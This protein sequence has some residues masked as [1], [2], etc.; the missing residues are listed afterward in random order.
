MV[1]FSKHHFQTKHKK[2]SSLG[3]FAFFPVK[4]HYIHHDPPFC[5]KRVA[6][7]Q[8]QRQYSP[9]LDV[10]HFSSLDFHR[11][12]GQRRNLMHYLQSSPIGVLLATGAGEKKIKAVVGE[13]KIGR[14]T[15][16]ISNITNPN[17]AVFFGKSLKITKQLH[18]V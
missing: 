18:Q 7:L 3:K 1:L 9:D 17:N 4:N 6:P 11:D 12:R 13:Q 8:S 5:R 14:N 10:W 15:K 2:I 16:G